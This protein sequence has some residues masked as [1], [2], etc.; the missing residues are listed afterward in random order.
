M[1]K[2]SLRQI[3]KI[4]ELFV[5]P[6]TAHDKYSLLNRD[7][8]F[9]HLLMQLSQKTKNFVSFFF[10]FLHFPN[11]DRILNIFK[12]KVTLIPD[13]FLDLRTPKNVLR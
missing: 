3:C 7:N 12:Q 11:L 8:L 4:L 5:N 6:L 13:V 10:F 9:Q 1:A 2:K